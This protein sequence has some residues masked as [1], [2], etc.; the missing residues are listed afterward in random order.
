MS[1][2]KKIS[3]VAPPRRLAA[4]LPE[5]AEWPGPVADST[6]DAPQLSKVLMSLQNTLVNLD[7]RI[8]KIA[9]ITNAKPAAVVPDEAH[10]SLMRQAVNT[11]RPAGY[12]FLLVVVPEDAHPRCE[13]FATVEA[14]IARI[15]ELLN[16]PCYLFPQI[17]QRLGITKGR[18]RFLTTS[19]GNFPLFD[20]PTMDEVV[21]TATGWVGIAELDE[22][23]I[24]AP[25]PQVVAEPVEPDT[26][27]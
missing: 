8:D 24:I 11:T 22:T 14:L 13:E 18:D 23:S 9:A 1:D 21:E 26:L 3:V 5:T 2:D 16:T 17:G 19:W 27:S 4:K 6:I 25:A 20:V 12:R 7:S 10:S 15:K